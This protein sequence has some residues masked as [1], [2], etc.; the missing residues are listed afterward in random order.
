M[1]KGE[2][3]LKKKRILKSDRAILKRS[4]LNLHQNTLNYFKIHV[5]SLDFKE[6]KKFKFKSLN[7]ANQDPNRK[8]IKKKK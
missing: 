8:Q 7:G 5:K 3:L 2:K 1:L 4:S 6:G